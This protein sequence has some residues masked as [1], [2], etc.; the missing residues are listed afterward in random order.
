VKHDCGGVEGA[1]EMVWI[2]RLRCVLR[3]R[4]LSSVNASERS[5][6]FAIPKS[7]TTI[8]AIQN[9][10][11]IIQDHVPHPLVFSDQQTPTTSSLPLPSNQSPSRSSSKYTYPSNSPRD[12]VY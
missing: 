7:S 2:T 10:H 8:E 11:T 4:P 9:T 12:A 1:N 3:W 5:I 6:R